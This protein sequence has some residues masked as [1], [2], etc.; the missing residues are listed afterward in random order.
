MIKLVSVLNQEEI[1]RSESFPMSRFWTIFSTQSISLLGS[2]IVQFSLVWWLTKMSGSASVLAVASIMVLIPQVFISPIAGAYVDRWNR[3]WIM[4]ATDGLIAFMVIILA[5]L[6]AFGLIQV[7]H[8]YTLMFLRAIGGAFHFP[9]M[10]ASTT[11]MVRK[12][13]LSRVAGLDRKSTRLNSSHT[14]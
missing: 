5:L 14:T 13:N 12:E 6:Y 4:I 3:R 1:G 11:L 7:W 2:Q 9:A 10:Q 8:I